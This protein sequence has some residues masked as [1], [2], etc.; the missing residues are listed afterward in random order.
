MKSVM[1]AVA[2]LFAVPPVLAENMAPRALD[3]K[4]V[5]FDH[6][7][8]GNAPKAVEIR[9]ADELTKSPL[10][11]DDASRSAV[12]KQVDF[13]A[14]KL[15]VFVWQGSG[16]DRLFSSATKDGTTV[17]FSHKVGATD[18]L[19]KHAHAFAVPKDATVEV[20]K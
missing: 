15:V 14:E 13:A 8:A 19:R 3:V 18:D 9:T 6:A 1:C 17:T 12:K 10:F 20:K 16:G 7:K 5:T 11:A 4:G 2:V